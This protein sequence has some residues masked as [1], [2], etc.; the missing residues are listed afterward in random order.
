M[1]EK[2][3]NLKKQPFHM[4]PDLRF[5][6]LSETHKQALAAII[7]GIQKRQGFLAI[8]GGVGVGK[9]TIVR[10]FLEKGT[11][12][13]LKVVYI[14]H[15][16]VTFTDILK[17]IYRDLDLEL[18]TT[19]LI[20]MV[21]G[22]HF[23]LIELYKQGKTVILMIDEAQTMSI[24]TLEKLRTL[25]NLET[26]TE[27]LIQVVLVG[28]TELE[29]MLEKHELRQLKQRIAIRAQIAPLSPLESHA[30]I[31][32]RLAVAGLDKPTIFSKQALD[33]IVREAKGVP[34]L[35]NVLCNNALITGFRSGKNP[36]TASI[37]REIV[38]AFA[39]KQKQPLIR[40]WKVAALVGAAV[41]LALVAAFFLS[42]RHG[43]VTTAPKRPVEQPPAAAEP[44]AAVKPES[45]LQPGAVTA[46]KEI[47]ERKAGA[48]AASY[49]TRVVKPA[50]TLSVLV[51]E[52]YRIGA[53]SALEPSL[54]DLVKQHNPAIT[55]ANL[56]LVGS[57]IRF[58]DRPREK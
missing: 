34:R 44:K 51:R 22:L 21:N 23:A 13:G 39:G 17:T 28:Q 55:D 24:E 26:P 25:S 19:D 11:G 32:H 5:L 18:A 45:A 8:T 43:P 36:V 49:K 20:G 6:Y 10:A 41:L 40:K 4:T 15:A 48:A 33:I 35:L 3:Y 57:S 58:P 30:Y 12:A 52:V 42:Y 2:F 14:I 9:T 53:K 37:A 7:Y 56:I 46:P 50:E 27:K 16:N 47:T 29:E 1:Y 31:S 38:T 54:I